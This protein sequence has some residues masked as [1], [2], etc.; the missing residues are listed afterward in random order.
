MWRMSEQRGVDV[1]NERLKWIRSG[2][3]V[4]MTKRSGVDVENDQAERSGCA[5]GAEWM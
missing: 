1:E 3:D 4:E 2:V 5:S